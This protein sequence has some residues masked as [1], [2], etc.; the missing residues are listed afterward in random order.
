MTD[1]QNAR[2]P[3]K[4]SKAECGRLG[5]LTTKERHGTEHFRRAGKLGFAASARA[6]AGN[7]PKA[8]VLWLQAHGKLTPPRPATL[9]DLQDLQ[10]LRDRLTPTQETIDHD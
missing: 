10:D 1:H 7:R 2:P 3:R 5:G 6:R 8:N 9:Q 4:L